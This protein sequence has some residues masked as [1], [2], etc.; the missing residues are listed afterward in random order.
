MLFFNEMKHTPILLALVVACTR[1]QSPVPPTP[2][3]AARC[4]AGDTERWKQIAFVETRG[5][6]SVSGLTG[7]VT[8]I[9]DVRDGRTRSDFTLGQIAGGDGYDGKVHWQK[10]PGGEVRIADAPEAIALARTEAW[11]S[12][13][14]YCSDAGARYRDLGTRERYTVI[15][16]V[17]EGGARV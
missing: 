11:L 3:S 14:G 9:E 5:T 8:S 2:Q 4:P 7:Q 1:S 12:R 17:P 13:R 6:V 10:D 16:A 15:E